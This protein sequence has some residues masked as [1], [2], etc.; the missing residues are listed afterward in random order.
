MYCFLLQLA[1]SEVLRSPQ[2]LV[3]VTLGVLATF[4]FRGLH[5]ALTRTFLVHFFNTHPKTVQISGLGFLNGMQ[6]R[7]Q[8]A[9]VDLSSEMLG[10]SGELVRVSAAAST[11]ARTLHVLGFMHQ[12]I[13]I[14]TSALFAKH[15]S[16]PSVAAHLLALFQF[17]FFDQFGDGTLSDVVIDMRLEHASEDLL[18]HLGETLLSF[19]V[20]DRLGHLLPEHRLDG[21]VRVMQLLDRVVL[22]VV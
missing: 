22:P 2:P 5:R 15:E 3:K 13:H 19:E 9:F 4:F 1:K 10:G 6:T 12:A 18:V 16:G 7:G 20:L 14:E 11:G 21:Q 17:L 8:L